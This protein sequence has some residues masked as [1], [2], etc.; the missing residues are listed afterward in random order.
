MIRPF[1]AWPNQRLETQGVALGWYNSPRWGFKHLGNSPLRFGHS[2]DCAYLAAGEKFG[3]RWQS[4]DGRYV[5]AATPLW[6]RAER[7]QARQQ[8]H[9][10]VDP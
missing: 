2:A 9:Y 7:A 6:L 10:R 4:P 1:R 8:G 3:V 5:G